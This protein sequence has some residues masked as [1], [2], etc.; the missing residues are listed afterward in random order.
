MID[1]KCIK[2]QAM[3]SAPESI[4]GQAMTCKCGNVC[5]VPAAAQAQRAPATPQAPAVEKVQPA[6]ETPQ[7]AHA[8][9]DKVLFRANPSMFRNHP[10]WFILL[11]ILL[12]VGIVVFPIWYLLCRGTVLTITETRSI[13]RTGLLSRDT[14]E[15]R[16][17]DVRNIQVNQQ[18][19]QRICGVG[20]IGISSA[21]QADMEIFAD[22]IRNPQAIAEAIRTRQG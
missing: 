13:L 16:H 9:D 3:L 1:F 2:C 20:S 8:A 11:I 17:R 4:A 12:P 7:P 6:S 19:W 18:A 22:G 14:N 15:I 10:V 21:A 5:Q